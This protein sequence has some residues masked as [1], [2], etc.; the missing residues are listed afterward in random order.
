[1]EKNKINYYDYHILIIISDGKIDDIQETIDSIIEASSY[2]VSFI[3]I[4]IGD[5]VTFDMR[6]LNGENGK[7]IS[8]KG[9]VLNKDI[10]QYV[11]FNFYANDLNKLT[12]EV[13]KYIPDQ[14]SKYY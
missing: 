11:H 3:I 12:K 10:V 8:S 5:D 2:P 13:L 1:M 14:I 7:L 9:K 6:T 4:G